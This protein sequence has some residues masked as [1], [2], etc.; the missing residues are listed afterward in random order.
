MNKWRNKQY[1]FGENRLYFVIHTAKA[2]TT[3]TSDRNDFAI[4]IQ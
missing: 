2:K 4:R 3:L 1:G